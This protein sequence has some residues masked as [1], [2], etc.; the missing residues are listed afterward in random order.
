MP[1]NVRF[2]DLSQNLITSLPHQINWSKLYG[3]NLSENGF[4]EWP[5]VIIPEAL[6]RLGYLIIGGNGFEN[7]PNF[8]NGFPSLRYLDL[9]ATRL[10]AIPPWIF[11]SLKLKAV[12]F[13]GSTRITDL[14]LD[15][16]AKFPEL[17]MADLTGLELPGGEEP[18]A[19]PP[20]CDLFV[21]K[22]LPP[23]RC[24]SG[25]ATLVI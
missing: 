21:L 11:A 6:P 7:T 3:L 20:Q 2:L 25:S 9:S 5:G 16:I 8:P 4:S 1:K 12:R 15:T 13:N 23:Q 14:K 24:P 17:R 19:L 10:Q 18:F 22:G